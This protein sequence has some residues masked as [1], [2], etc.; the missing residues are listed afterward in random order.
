M[1]NIVA[2]IEKFVRYASFDF[3]ITEYRLLLV[4]TS[5]EILE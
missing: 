2:R 5:A 4:L 3:M 1:K